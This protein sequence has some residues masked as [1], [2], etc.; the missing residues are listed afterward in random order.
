MACE[1]GVILRGH[2]QSSHVCPKTSS[3]V[4]RRACEGRR[5]VRA[6]LDSVAYRNAKAACP[7]A[8][9]RPPACGTTPHWSSWTSPCSTI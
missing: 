9:Q 8:H 5:A 7:L 4:H 2:L 6:H 3:G 1:E